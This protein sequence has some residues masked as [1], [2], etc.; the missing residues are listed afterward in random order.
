M[1]CSVRCSS[2]CSRG[3]GS[4]QSG[5]RH[6]NRLQW[7]S[8]SAKLDAAMSFLLWHN[9]KHSDD[10]KLSQ[11]YYFT[12]LNRLHS[13]EV[14]LMLS[15]SL[16]SVLNINRIDMTIQH[17]Q[18]LQIW[19]NIANI[20]LSSSIKH[21]EIKQTDVPASTKHCFFVLVCHCC[22]LKSP[23]LQLLQNR[24]WNLQSTVIEIIMAKLRRLLL[25][26][27][28]IRPSVYSLFRLF[29]FS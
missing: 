3:T 15:L 6:K 7:G 25:I 16:L 8:W 28:F 20:T 10:I 23:V 9:T 27:D 11:G 13:S 18:N 29:L 21:N 17:F 19:T 12:N 1:C 14:S 22:V 24:N 4:S 26:E 2:S 5:Q